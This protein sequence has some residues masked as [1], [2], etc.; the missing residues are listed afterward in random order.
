[1]VSAY[2][3]GQVGCAAGAGVIFMEVADGTVFRGYGHCGKIVAVADCLGRSV[4]VF[5]F[6]SR[7]RAGEKEGGIGI[8]GNH[9][10]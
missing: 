3:E 10:Q 5:S 8:P 6:D 1:M 4:V 7:S 2:E 9:R